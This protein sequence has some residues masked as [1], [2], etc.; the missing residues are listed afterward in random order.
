MPHTLLGLRRA[1]STLPSVPSASLAGDHRASFVAPLK[2]VAPSGLGL[3][4][5]PRWYGKRFVLDPSS[6]N[7]AGTNLLR[8]K[9]TA[10]DLQETMPMTVRDGLSLIDGQPAVVIDYAPGTR[11]PW[12]WVRDELRAL[13]DGSLVGMTV[14]DLPVLRWLGGTPF[15]L[16]RSDS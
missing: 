3:I 1:W 8:V 15:L 5:L 4:G 9:G 10:G 12:P 6:E 16:H 11:A 13:P 2:R 7:V 14:V